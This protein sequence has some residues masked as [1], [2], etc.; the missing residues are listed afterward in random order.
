M[1]ITPISAEQANEQSVGDPW[2]AGEYDFTIYEATETTSQGGNEQIKLILHVFNRSGQ[3]RT[4]FDYLV[5]SEKSQWKIRHFS[6]AVGLLRQY[7]T[8]NL[9]A[10]DMPGKSGRCKLR[11]KPAEGT[12]SAQNAVNDY[13]TVVGTVV[14]A[15][16][17]RYDKNQPAVRPAAPNDLDDEIPF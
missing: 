2:P 15:M 11:I 13:V 8:G 12:Y 3:K 14:G 5:N 6:E 17:D 16:M 9:I 1:R 10:H 4:V 7:E